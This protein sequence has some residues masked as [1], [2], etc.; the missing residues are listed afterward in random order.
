MR[1][2]FLYVLL[3]LFLAFN[4][5][6]LHAESVESLVIKT[7]T[8][9]LDYFNQ[10]PRVNTAIIKYENHSDFPDIFSQ[11]FY[12]ML[13]ARL[14]TS[15]RISITDLMINFSNK[16]GE[17]NLTRIEKLNFT[18]GW[19]Y[20]DVDSGDDEEVFV[21]LGY[22]CILAPEVSVWRGIEYGESWYTN[23]ALSHSFEFENG[24]SLDL[25]TNAGWW[26]HPGGDDSY[27]AW[28]D[29]NFS[30]GYNI[31]LDEFWT[32]SASINYTTTLS[33]EAEDLAKEISFDGDD[34]DFIYGGVTIATSF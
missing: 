30:A 34:N 17:F 11:R 23:F 31:P 5:T 21:V 29:L 7:S 27:D 15:N 33:S 25:G 32:F 1:N 18:L 6:A 4:V 14:E 12:Q 19:I 24:H 2:V 26:Y 3:C 13:I 16:E 10:H 28:H 22:D 8:G 9:I 20:Y